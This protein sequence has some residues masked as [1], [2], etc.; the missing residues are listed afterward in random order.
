M[1]VADLI[2]WIAMGLAFGA[3]VKR[4]TSF[5]V[6]LAALLIVAVIGAVIG[7]VYGM[8]ASPGSGASGSAFAL[9]SA[10]VVSLSLVL[11]FAVIGSGA[12]REDGSTSMRSV[13]APLFVAIVV[14]LAA[15]AFWSAVQSD[16]S[17]RDPNGGPILRDVQLA[18]S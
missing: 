17:P 1:P 3:L 11:L 4:F 15:L 12:K 9:A 13:L 14:G 16:P 8:L 7:G 10:A 2:V 6:S 5:R 18:P